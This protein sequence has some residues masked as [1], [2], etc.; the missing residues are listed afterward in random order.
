[1]SLEIVFLYVMFIFLS[2]AFWEAY[3]EGPHGWAE[4][5]YGWR[6][7][8]GIVEL[9]AYHF[10]AWIVMIPLFLFLPLVIFGFDK[11]I[12]WFLVGCYFFGAV[13]EDFMWFIVNPKF[14]LR[15]FNSKK[16]KWHKWLRIGR[17]EI[18]LFY[19]I[20]LVISLFVFLVLV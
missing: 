14:P 6:I 3:V 18:P 12:F 8:L 9:T 1:M 10:W 16:V 13:F 17:L 15:N 5:S 4:K 11:S 7:D 19:I 2:I 20:Y